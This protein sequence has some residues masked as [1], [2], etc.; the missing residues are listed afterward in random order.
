MAFDAGSIE[1]KLTLDRSEFQD[2]LDIARRE[3]KDFEDSRHE[4]NIKV[5]LDDAEAKARMDEFLAREDARDIRTKDKV[6][7]DRSGG[8]SGGLKDI[9]ILSTLSG[10]APGG[11]SALGSLAGLLPTLT[12]GAGG[13]GLALGALG[14]AVAAL[15]PPALGAVAGMGALE[16]GMDGIK[17][18][19]NQLHPRT[20]A[21]KT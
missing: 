21:L 15:G 10:I 18:A 20:T 13:A 12:L 19:A 9:S 14:G 17:N 2:G 1:A 7:T 4:V 8:D 3:V 5:D 6:E 16:L 11:T